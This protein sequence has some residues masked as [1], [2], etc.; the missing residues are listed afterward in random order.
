MWQCFIFIF[1]PVQT[2]MLSFP[3]LMLAGLMFILLLFQ[4]LNNDYYFCHTVKDNYFFFFLKKEKEYPRS[5]K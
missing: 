3:K 1:Y 5:D 4:M 2:Y